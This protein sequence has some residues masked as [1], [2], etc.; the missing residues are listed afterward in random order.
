MILSR[1]KG[2][3]HLS[4]V[5]PFLQG[6]FPIG[7]EGGTTYD[8]RCRAPSSTDLLRLLLFKNQP[9]TITIR[10]RSQFSLMPH[11]KLPLLDGARGA[12]S[13]LMTSDC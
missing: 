3:G 9:A 6:M 4:S 13:R 12:S 5:L 7:R 8:V 2:D 11:D 10:Y 1:F